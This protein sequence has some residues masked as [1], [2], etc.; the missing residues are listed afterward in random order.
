ML[1]KDY[2]IVLRA[3]L[4]FLR[5]KKNA[6]NRENESY[7]YGYL[8]IKQQ[9]LSPTENLNKVREMSQNELYSFLKSE[10]SPNQRM[11]MIDTALD[12]NDLDMVIKIS[13]FEK[14]IKN[15][16]TTSGEFI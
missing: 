11:R 8:K 12:E 16:Y 10:T 7:E 6:V 4:E 1:L 5:T 14:N 15:I 9:T 2:A 3:F 13:E